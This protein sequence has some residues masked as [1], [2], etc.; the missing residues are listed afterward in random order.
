[1]QWTEEELDELGI[2]GLGQDAKPFDEVF[3]NVNDF[4]PSSSDYELLDNC[5]NTYAQLASEWVGQIDEI[6][7]E[8]DDAEVQSDDEQDRAREVQVHHSAGQTALLLEIAQ[9]DSEADGE[10]DEE[11]QTRPT[12]HP[13]TTVYE[14]NNVIH[15]PAIEGD[16]NATDKV[17]A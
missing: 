15:I 16:L 9:L 6:M 7:R 12:I 10:S 11:E 8:D 13:R 17:S 5:A 2:T 1:M 14:D 4:L 3:R